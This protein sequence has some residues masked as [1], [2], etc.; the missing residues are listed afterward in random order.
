MTLSNQIIQ[1][2]PVRATN[3]TR[4]PKPSLVDERVD[5]PLEETAWTSSSP[6]TYTISISSTPDT[7]VDPVERTWSE[8]AKLKD[9]INET[10]ATSADGALVDAVKPGDVSTTPIAMAGFT[11][12][13]QSPDSNLQHHDS[14]EGFTTPPSHLSWTAPGKDEVRRPSP[15]LLES[16]KE[17][18]TSMSLNEVFNP[19]VHLS[20]SKLNATASEFVPCDSRRASL[21][22]FTESRKASMVLLDSCRRPSINTDV[23]PESSQ[24]WSVNWTWNSSQWW[25]YTRSASSNPRTA[26]PGIVQRDCARRAFYLGTNDI[27]IDAN[28]HSVSSTNRREIPLFPPGLR[29]PSLL[30][31]AKWPAEDLEHVQNLKT[32]GTSK[33]WVDH[34]HYL[35]MLEARMDPVYAL[36]QRVRVAQYLVECCQAGSSS[37]GMYALVQAFV[38]ASTRLSVHAT[39]TIGC[40]LPTDPAY[41]AGLMVKRQAVASRLAEGFGAMASQVVAALVNKAGD[42]VAVVFAWRLCDA[43]VHEFYRR[44]GGRGAGDKDEEKQDMDKDELAANLDVCRSLGALRMFGVLPTE[45]VKVCLETLLDN[46][47]SVGHVDA[48]GFFIAGMGAD[49]FVPREWHKLLGRVPRPGSADWDMLVRMYTGACTKMEWVLKWLSRQTGERWEDKLLVDQRVMD[50]QWMVDGFRQNLHD[51][52]VGIV[53]H[54]DVDTVIQ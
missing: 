50:I 12:L 10:D 52:L 24:V 4:R 3:L 25:C 53:Q 37:Q 7:L 36:S 33:H 16:L 42:R 30:R 5:T 45:H 48:L 31:H 32:L 35:N 15:D 40:D 22:A 41:N 19:R 8:L 18:E 17:D 21:A 13:L 11:S 54:H 23:D 14:Q 9:L 39:D 47:S 28:A 49:G 2:S 46:L 20:E 43:L 44:W 29:P 51:N 27:D 34:S 6:D 1:P 26:T 38:K